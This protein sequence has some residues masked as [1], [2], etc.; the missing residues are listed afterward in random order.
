MDFEIQIKELLGQQKNSEKITDFL[1]RLEI[2][3]TEKVSNGPTFHIEVKT[4]SDAE[5]YSKAK[6]K[7]TVRRREYGN[8][9]VRYKIFWIESVF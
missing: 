6:T 1:K 5:Y 4:F 9:T 7:H 8:V 3:Y 2:I